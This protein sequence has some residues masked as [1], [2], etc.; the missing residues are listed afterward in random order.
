MLPER[1]SRKYSPVHTG[2]AHKLK[3]IN[4]TVLVEQRKE[5]I[6]CSLYC[7][8][9]CWLISEGNLTNKNLS[10]FIFQREV[11]GMRSVMAVPYSSGQLGPAW[12]ACGT[13]CLRCTRAQPTGTGTS[14]PLQAQSPA[15]CRTSA[16]PRLRPHTRPRR[17]A[18][19][20]AGPCLALTSWVDVAPPG[21]LRALACGRR[22]RSGG[23]TAGAVSS[24][25]ASETHS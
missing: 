21:A 20:S 2:L 1:N 22:W 9:Y 11:G 5:D 14:A 18:S 6:D 4:W 8:T 3:K 10:L 13:S 16:W 17:P 25:A 12:K 23:A 15:C 19:G 7:G 24:A